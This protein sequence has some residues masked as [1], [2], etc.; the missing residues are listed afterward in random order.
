[1]DSA[2]KVGTLLDYGEDAVDSGFSVETVR[3]VE[4]VDVRDWVDGVFCAT[5][6]CV[7]KT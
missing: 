1:M 4:L 7:V 3:T 2:V 5:S 6:V